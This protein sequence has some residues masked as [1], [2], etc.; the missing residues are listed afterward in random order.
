M[1]LFCLSSS[2]RTKDSSLQLATPMMLR[3]ASIRRGSLPPKSREAREVSSSKA[4]SA[5]MVNCGRKSAYS[6]FSEVPIH[7]ASSK[8]FPL[9]LLH[10]ADRHRTTMSPN[11][12]LFFMSMVFNYSQRYKEKMRK[13]FVSLILLFAISEVRM[14]RSV[15][16]SE[17]QSC[18]PVRSPCSLMLCR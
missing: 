15:P 16:A 18:L 3:S 7:F 6:T 12:K 2:T 4:M 11:K 13:T 17:R 9:S 5:D 1:S 8:G 10:D 14:C